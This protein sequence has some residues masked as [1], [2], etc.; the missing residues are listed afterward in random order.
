MLPTYQKPH[1]TACRG[2]DSKF[3]SLCW[4]FAC[5]PTTSIVRSSRFE[6]KSNISLSVRNHM[7]Q[8]PTTMS[9]EG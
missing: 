9:I 7:Y 2:Q 3:L 8:S 1:M 5:S 4:S 6:G